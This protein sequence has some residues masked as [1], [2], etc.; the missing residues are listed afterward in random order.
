MFARAVGVPRKPASSASKAT[1]AML[2]PE[3]TSRA[4]ERKTNTVGAVKDGANALAPRLAT[5][6]TRTIVPVMRRHVET[7]VAETR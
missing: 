7:M 4:V 5:T 3:T 1:C 6:P 2:V